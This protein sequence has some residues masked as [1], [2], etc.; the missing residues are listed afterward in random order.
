MTRVLITAIAALGLALPAAAAPET[1]TAD[2]DHTFPSFELS[3]GNDFTITRGFFQKTSGKIT[4]DRAAKTGSIEIVV[5]VAS[6]TT[7]Q[8]ARDRIVR[9]N[10]FKAEQFPNMT[11][12]SDNLKFDG[13]TLVGADGELTLAGVTRPVSLTVTSFKCRP[14]PVNKKE[15]C[16]ADGTARIKRSDF[17]L[18]AASSVGNDVKILFQIEAYKD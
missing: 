14:H 5:D 4:L 2:P 18:N 7:G 15:Q 1:Y 12:R 6:M 11:Y 9:T 17:G 13:E 16:G 10:W 8:Q 3:H